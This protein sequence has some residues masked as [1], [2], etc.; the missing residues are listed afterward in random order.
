MRNAFGRVGPLL[1]ALL[2]ALAVTVVFLPA[3]AFAQD[4]APQE[5]DSSSA[6]A[7]LMIWLSWAIGAVI[8]LLS[9]AS[10]GFIIE[11]F[12]TLRRSRLIPEQ[13]LIEL[14][15]QIARGQIPQAIEYCHLPENESMASDLI[16]AGL[17]RYRSTEFGFAEYKTAVEEAGENYLGQLYRKTE[18]LGVIGA[19]SP[20]LGLMGTVS[21]MI[22]AFGTIASAT[23]GTTPSDLAGGIMGALITTLLGLVVAVPALVFFSFFRNKIDSIVAE[24]GRRI[25]RV[26]SPLGRKR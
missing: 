21:G 26:M 3:T 11:H 8:V 4:S 19:I 5:G 12:I 25:E 23:G 9:L 7:V 6:I 13:V 18:V 22:S 16:L 2:I 14:E 15:E 17:E 1:S 20:M 10:I 24:A